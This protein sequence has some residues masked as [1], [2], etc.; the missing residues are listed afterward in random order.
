[1]RKRGSG[2]A[3]HEA[4]TGILEVQIFEYEEA[5][6]HLNEMAARGWALREI[7]LAWMPVACYEKD[8]GADG[9]T[10]T[11]EVM[12]ELEDEDLLVLCQ[13]AGWERILQLRNGMWIF[14]TKE[15]AARR[16]FFDTEARR[17]AAWENY[18]SNSQGALTVV[19]LLLI[20][21]ILFGIWWA[22]RG[23]EISWYMKS[24]FWGFLAVMALMVP[25]EIGNRLWMRKGSFSKAGCF[26]G[27]R[28]KWL[29]RL[30]E[31]EY[32]G[33][34]FAIAAILILKIL[35]CATAGST[36]GVI[37]CVMSPL[38]FMA[39]AW[40][41]LIWRKTVLGWGVMCLGVMAFFM[42]L[43]VLWQI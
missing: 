31:L 15:K 24:L 32:Y 43:S 11:A 30:S 14:R 9:Y 37:W 6:V 41:R 13:D 1:M 39:G 4:Q 3:E 36:I 5:T 19:C 2:E 12:T 17:E 23:L 22:R 25:A 16:L 33:G 21:G 8:D 10:Y 35:Q 7:T 20:G 26:E 42:D 29:R 34:N 40:I 28:P 18:R 27:G 38:V